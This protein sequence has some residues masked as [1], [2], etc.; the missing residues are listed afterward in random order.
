V[1]MVLTHRSLDDDDVLAQ[2]VFHDAAAFSRWWST[3][4]NDHLS[5]SQQP[6]LSRECTGDG[7]WPARLARWYH[8]G[9]RTALT[10]QASTYCSGV[11]RLDGGGV[12]VQVVPRT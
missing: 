6:R 9:M 1:Q 8:G 7:G 4:A 3:T 11:D 12:V 2:V 10:S 5:T